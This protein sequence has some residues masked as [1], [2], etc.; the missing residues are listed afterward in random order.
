M[1]LSVKDRINAFIQHKKI[2]VRAFEMRCGFSNGYLR[3]LRNS[4]TVD[5]M[6]M[7]L[8][9]FPEINREWLTTGEGEMLN[10]SAQTTEQQGDNFSRRIIE[11]LMAHIDQLKEQ[12]QTMNCKCQEQEKYIEELQREIDNETA[13]K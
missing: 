13:Q 4:P 3:Q 10:Q 8:S 7:I 12:L 1:E 2:S 11:T 9:A 5:K 6:E